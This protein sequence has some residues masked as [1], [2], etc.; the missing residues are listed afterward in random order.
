[1]R[2]RRRLAVLLI[3]GTVGTSAYLVARRYSIDIVSYVVAQ[4]LLQKA[5]PNM[6][7]A[8]LQ[9]ELAQYLAS[10]QGRDERLQR[11]MDLAAQLEK[12]QRLD[13]YDIARLLGGQRP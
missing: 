13:S 7:R 3:F 8:E 4:T 6:D 2:L 10:A 1:M 12:V 5:P 9:R 11:L